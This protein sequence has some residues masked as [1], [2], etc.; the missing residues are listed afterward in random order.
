MT[1]GTST[2][3]NGNPAAD[4]ASTAQGG[5]ALGP[6]RHTSRKSRRLSRRP[7]RLSLSNWSVSTRLVGVFM[8]ASVTGLVFGG[9]RV[10]DAISTSDAYGRTAQ[11]ALLGEQAT[12]LAQ[13]MEDER[14]LSA[15]YA[16]YGIL[17][18][19][20]KNGRKKVAVKI[21]IG[22]GTKMEIL[23]GLKPGDKVVLPS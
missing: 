2:P 22:N 9:L 16:A 1:I 7:A 6:G 17:A 13:A 3:P 15:G 5:N 12:N 21:G 19:D 14:D 18:A 11:V 23:D 4:A 10:S 8:V 20:A